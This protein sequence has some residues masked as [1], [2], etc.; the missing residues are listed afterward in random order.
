MPYMR[1]IRR[2]RRAGPLARLRANRSHEALASR[3]S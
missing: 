1:T 3:G 2:E